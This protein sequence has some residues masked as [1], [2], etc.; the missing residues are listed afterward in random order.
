MTVATGCSENSNHGGCQA[1]ISGADG[2]AT[3]DLS[4]H[5]LG[6]LL[7]S[8]SQDRTIKFWSRN[9]PGDP[10]TD[11]YNANQLADAEAREAAVQALLDTESKKPAKK[12][13]RLHP[14]MIGLVAANGEAD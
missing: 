12:R 13:A 1:D 9:R 4:W 11:R 7:L 2:G 14:R 6:H 5:P 8:A 3:W 10:M